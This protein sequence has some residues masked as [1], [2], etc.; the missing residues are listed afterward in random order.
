MTSKISL[1]VAVFLFA[2]S[3]AAFAGTAHVPTHSTTA[4]QARQSFNWVVPSSADEPNAHRYHGG[5]KSND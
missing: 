3:G 1:T 4:A 2:L 5:P